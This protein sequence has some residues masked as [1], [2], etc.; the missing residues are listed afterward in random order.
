MTQPETRPIEDI[1]KALQSVC[2]RYTAEKALIVMQAIDELERLRAEKRRFPVQ[3]GGTIPWALA[4]AAYRVYSA[5]YGKDQSLERLAERGGFHASEMDI[6][7]PDWR[8]K[9]LEID[10]GISAVRAENDALRTLADERSESLHKLTD[11]YQ[12]REGWFR[13]ENDALRKALEAEERCW[14]HE[15][16]CNRC[17]LDG[18]CDTGEELRYRADTMRV[19]ALAL[20]DRTKSD[21]RGGQNL[22]SDVGPSRSEEVG[23]VMTHT[24][25]DAPLD[26]I[27]LVNETHFSWGDRLR[28]LLGKPFHSHFA[29]DVWNAHVSDGGRFITKVSSSRNWVEPLGRPRPEGAYAIGEREV[30]EERGE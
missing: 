20:D 3:K 6:F 26:T 23:A 10:S 15:D 13:G 11:C 25:T 17:R 5:K 2:G 21:A 8:A 12:K 4:E 27:H 16:D 24:E 28:I 9:A 18:E 19:D 22:G 14:E 1:R 7:V 30:V 29:I